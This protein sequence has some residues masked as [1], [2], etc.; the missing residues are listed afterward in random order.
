[1]FSGKEGPR[2]GH[3]MPGIQTGAEQISRLSALPS[4]LFFVYTREEEEIQ[5]TPA[6]NLLGKFLHSIICWGMPIGPGVICP[7]LATMEQRWARLS[8]R[9]EGRRHGRWPIICSLWP[10]GYRTLCR[11]R[12]RA[13]SHPELPPACWQWGMRDWS[14]IHLPACH[15]LHHWII[16]LAN[17]T[18][19]SLGI[20]LRWNNAYDNT[21][22]PH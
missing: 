5:A 1:M 4:T 21:I 9:V 18:L 11:R 8:D 15:I 19:G 2:L 20:G 13:N 17:S 16:Q 6:I 12:V 22:N 3:W 7:S 14:S 10:V